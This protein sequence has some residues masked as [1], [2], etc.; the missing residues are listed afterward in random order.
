V[1]S[2]AGLDGCEKSVPTFVS[3]DCANL[4]KISTKLF[5][6]SP[7]ISFEVKGIK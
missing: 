4:P 3:V 7:E 1:G 2:R 5:E 6:F